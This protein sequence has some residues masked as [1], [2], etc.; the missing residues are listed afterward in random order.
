MK[1]KHV[2][3]FVVLLGKAPSVISSCVVVNKL[4]ATPKR[5]RYSACLFSGG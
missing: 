2:S 4:P 3:F 5:F 1:N